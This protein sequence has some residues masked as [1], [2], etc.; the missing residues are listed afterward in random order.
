METGP[1]LP[2]MRPVAPGARRRPEVS[3]M[4]RIYEWNFSSL[5]EPVVAGLLAFTLAIVVLGV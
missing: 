5:A 1:G 2:G 4:F 3:A